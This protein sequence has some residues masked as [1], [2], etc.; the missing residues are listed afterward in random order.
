MF[1][2]L[3]LQIVLLQLSILAFPVAFFFPFFSKLISFSYLSISKQQQCHLFTFSSINSLSFKSLTEVSPKL[4]SLLKILL[5]TLKIL[6]VFR[7]MNIKTGHKH[8]YSNHIATK[9]QNSIT[10][11]CS[12]NIFP[13][14]KT[15]ELFRSFNHRIGDKCLKNQTKSHPL[16]LTLDRIQS[17]LEVADKEQ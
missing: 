10:S 4:D 13:Y 17:G 6:N 2:I 16:R 11:V 5:K 1:S 15:Q 14:Y 12:G 8:S 3:S 7:N 9:Y